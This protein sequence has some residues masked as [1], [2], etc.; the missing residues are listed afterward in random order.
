VSAEIYPFGKNRYSP[1]ATKKTK[2]A[3]SIEDIKKIYEYEPINDSEY[4]AR[5]MWLFSYFGNG[6]NVKD[7]ALLKYKNIIDGEI[8]LVRAKT[9][10]SIMNEEKIIQIILT[11]DL[12]R[13]IKKWGSKTSSPNNYI[14]DITS[15]GSDAKQEYR[16]INQAIKTINKY[17]KRIADK[18]N[19]ERVPT[20]NFA[21]H[22]FSTVLKR[23]GVSVEMISEQLGHS[24]IKT[25]E[26]YLSSFEKEQRKEIPNLLL[27]FKKKHHKH[28]RLH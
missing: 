1:P 7:I 10:N 22:S 12:K 23:A 2:K 19:L 20:T 6:I 11:E 16:D 13:I 27:A 26:I 21:R 17:M 3:L 15:T 14:F 25:T 18:L 9:K 8:H 4:W 24:N 28:K 5:D